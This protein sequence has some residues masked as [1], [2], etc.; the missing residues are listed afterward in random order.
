LHLAQRCTTQPHAAAQDQTFPHHELAFRQHDLAAG[1]GHGINRR[2][3][4]II[5]LG[6]VQKFLRVHRGETVGFWCCGGLL[7]I[8]FGRRD[9][10]VGV[11]SAQQS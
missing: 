11:K 7:E 6:G 9:R 4:T 3:K 5:R 2:L 10:H 1:Y 8:V